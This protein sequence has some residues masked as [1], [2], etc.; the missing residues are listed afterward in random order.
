MISKLTGSLGSETPCQ[1]GQPGRDVASGWSWRIN[2]GMN[3]GISAWT[4]V[5][6]RI[7]CKLRP[8]RRSATCHL[9][10]L[11][12]VLGTDRQRVGYISGRASQ[13]G[14]PQK[15]PGIIHAWKKQCNEFTEAG[16]LAL[17]YKQTVSGG[18]LE[19]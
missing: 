9:V 4:C 6:H 2:Q 19:G 17:I 11:V 7:T 16:C 5:K 12:D 3:S 1:M 8:P 13:A 10:V 15:E 18:Y 14:L